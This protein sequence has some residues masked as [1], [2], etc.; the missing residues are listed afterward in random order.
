MCVM[1]VI[2]YIWVGKKRREREKNGGPH[3]DAGHTSDQGLTAGQVD[4]QGLLSRQAESNVIRPVRRVT[5]LQP[6]DD[7]RLVWESVASWD[8][9]WLRAS[10]WRRQEQQHSRRQATATRQGTQATQCGPSMSDSWLVD[11]NYSVLR[12]RSVDRVLE[13]AIAY[14]DNSKSCRECFR[15]VSSMK[16]PKTSQNLSSVLNVE[17]SFSIADPN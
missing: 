1:L 14:R 6:I 8:R 12:L 10:L 13:M 4:R 2:L 16:T 17:G 11:K 15:G 7:S 5:W 3:H 9:A